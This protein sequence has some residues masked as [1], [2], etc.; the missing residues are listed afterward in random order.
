MAIRE[1]GAKRDFHDYRDKF[2]PPGVV[3]STLPPRVDLRSYAGPIKDQG[4]EGSCT[5][6]AGSSDVEWQFRRYRNQSPILSPA[7]LYAN[8]LIKEGTFPNDDGAQPRTICQILNQVGVCEEG[9]DPYVAGQIEKPSDTAAANAA[10]YKLG[11]YHRLTGLQDVLSCLGNA[12]PW[13]VL[14]SF[15]VYESFESENVQDTGMMP[16]PNVNSEELLGGHEVICLGYDL[17]AGLILCQNSWGPAWGQSGFFQMPFEV[18]N[19]QNLCP[20]L[21]IIHLGHWG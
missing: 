12:T 2:L 7:D 9:I 20:D 14:V 18:V 13:P 3:P 11:G 21:W 1:Y 17:K 16:V 8:E 19:N 4:Q 5:G 6:H 15:Q 10:Q